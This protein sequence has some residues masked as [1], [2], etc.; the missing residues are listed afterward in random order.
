MGS[1][2]V[3]HE[4][5]VTAFIVRISGETTER[6]VAACFRQFEATV[7]ERAGHGGFNVIL[8]VDEAAHSSIAV[9]RLIRQAL[10]SQKHR[11]RLVEVVGVSDDASQVATSRGGGEMLLFR[12]EAQAVEYLAREGP[13]GSPRR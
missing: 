5:S 2:A 4:P 10:E 3:V 8:N 7:E 1:C 6:D 13:P 9:V 11:D 12:D